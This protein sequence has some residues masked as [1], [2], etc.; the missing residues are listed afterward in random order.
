MKLLT[1]ILTFAMLT[2][3]AAMAASVPVPERATFNSA[4][5]LTS[6][7]TDGMQLPIQGELFVTFDG[8]VR[9]TLQPHDQRSPIFRVGDELHWKGLATF[10]NS[11]QAQFDALWTESPKVVS[12]E[13]TAI[14][15]A[16]ATPDAPAF[17]GPLLVKTVEYDVNL[18]R[19]EFEGWSFGAAGSVLPLIKPANPE[20]FHEKTDKLVFTDPEK[21]RTLTLA[22]DQVRDVSVTDI[23]EGDTRAYR[24]RIRMGGGVWNHGDALKLGLT[25]EFTGHGHGSVAHVSVNPAVQRYTFDGFGGNYC[26]QTETPAADFLFS[27]LRNAW[28]RL[29]FKAQDWDRERGH[30]GPALIRDFQ[31]MQRMQQHHIPWVLSLW[32]LPERFYTDPNQK[33]FYTFG[34]QIAPDRWP[35]FLDLLGSYLLYLKKNYG[36]E[37]TLF[38]FNEP[39]LGVS[40]GFSPEQ[41]REAIRRIGAY[42]QSLGLKT[43]M[44]LGDTANPR[45]THHYVLAAAA[46]P[47]AMRYVG[48]VSF[49]SWGDGTAAQYRAW[50][51]V[52]Q[53]LHLPLLVAEAGVDP[54]A[55][56]NRTFDS[57][58]YGLQEARQFQQLLRDARPTA[59]IFWQ[60]TED[61]GLVRVGPDKSIQ[62]T[63]RYWLMR[64]FA[65]R[66]PPDARVLA[67]SSDRKDVY[68]SAFS[69]GGRLVV[70]V[71]NLG[72]ARDLD[73]TGLPAGAWTTETTT[74]LRG[75]EVKTGI[76]V[77]APVPLAARSLTTFIRK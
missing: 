70:H 23:W 47:E 28:A 21:N 13:A 53:W 12:V 6:L 64:Q 30:P 72:P 3:A 35:E 67:S 39:D 50:A 26:F 24:V 77:A 37:P 36:A 62:E 51:D 61:Y 15:G 44:L 34:R 5:A 10:P 31:L 52:A 33:P 69:G 20:F 17:K 46:D 73:L 19:A 2:G 25:F 38:S 57:Y 9:A 63:A 14:S 66:T 60:F 55:Y 54:G 43:K 11:S 65:N 58:S 48:A 7:I 18:P 32:R 8:G 68:V 4:G 59:M 22:L 41:H 40:I 75:G 49:H 1:P 74:E 71:L 42:L 29:E 56:R 16:P 76:D 27:H 45:D